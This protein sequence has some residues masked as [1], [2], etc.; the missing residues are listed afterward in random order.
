MAKLALLSVRDKIHEMKIMEISFFYSLNIIYFGARVYVG[1]YSLVPNRA[2]G[3]G[4]LHP[5]TQSWGQL[6]HLP[7]VPTPLV[8]CLLAR[9]R[10][11]GI[12]PTGLYFHGLVKMDES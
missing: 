2:W 7:P 8:S 12:V 4:A 5:R 1:I 11:I 9:S 10:T 6:P 3:P